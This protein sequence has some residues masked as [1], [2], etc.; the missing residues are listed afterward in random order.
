MNTNNPAKKFLFIVQGEGR[1]HMTQAISLYHMLISNGHEVCEVVV[2]KSARRKIPEFFYQKLANTKIDTIESPNFVTD[3]NNKSIKIRRTIYA[4][5]KRFKIFKQS[6]RTLHGKVM[7]HQPDVIVNFYDFLGGIY[8]RF[9]RH[10]CQFVCIAHQ[11]LAA[12]PDFPFAKGNFWDR[13]TL[14]LGNLITSMRADKRL[15]LSFTE[16]YQSGSGLVV[17]P[18]L[19]RREVHQVEPSDEGF[20]LV[21]M[22]NDGYAEEVMRFHKLHPDVHLHCFWD[23]QNAQETESVDETLTFHQISD[24]KFLDKMS[25]CSGYASTAGFESICE[26]MLLGKPVMMVPVAKQYEQACNAIDAQRAGAGISSSEFDISKLMHYLKIH[27]SDSA[28]FRSW[29]G[30]CESIILPE[31]TTDGPN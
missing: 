17:T 12:H 8:N 1:G 28:R 6:L 27:R 20:I 5:L 9:Y 25:K 31:L 15:A 2:G 30:R 26:A 24:T 18:P 16:D 22:V 23:R 29:V 11:Y 19:L 14:K 10:N 7:Q 21:Y 3:K 13:A 4:N